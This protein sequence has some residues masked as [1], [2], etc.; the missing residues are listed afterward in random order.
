MKKSF[1]MTFILDFPSEDLSLM[2]KIL[3]RDLK[4]IKK[5]KIKKF[6]NE[7]FLGLKLAN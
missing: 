4:P 3:D 7:S 2:E 5:E 1:R 6:L